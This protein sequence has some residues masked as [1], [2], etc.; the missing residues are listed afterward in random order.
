MAT[1]NTFLSIKP[2]LKDTYSSKDRW[3]KLKLKLKL[4]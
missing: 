4:C 2:E 3:K 1:T